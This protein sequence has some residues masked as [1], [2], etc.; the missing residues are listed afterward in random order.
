MSET[1]MMPIG[2]LAKLTGCKIE[3]IRYYERIGLLP[4]PHRS[5][6][7]HRLYD[8]RARDRL[9]FIRH[10]RDLGFPL[11]AIRELLDLAD[12]PERSCAK[13]DAIAR[14]RLAEVDSRL[15]RL[16]AL[17]TELQRMI[18]ECQGGQ[19]ADCRVIEV[20]ADHRLCLADDHGKRD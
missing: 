15:S 18:G 10:G 13:A 4:P 14:A 6:G 12:V 16:M 11:D 9:M 3:T 20:L 2:R 8:R 1:V 5:S 7:G 19:I 17:R